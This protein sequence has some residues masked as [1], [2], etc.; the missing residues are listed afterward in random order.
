MPFSFF[1]YTANSTHELS[2]NQ[3]YYH[4]ELRLLLFLKSNSGQVLFA[5]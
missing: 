1:T 4:R 2:E 5:I 3:M